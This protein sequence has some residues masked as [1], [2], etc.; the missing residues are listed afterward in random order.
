VTPYDPNDP[1]TR[2]RIEEA[3]GAL[4]AAVGRFEAAGAPP[5]EAAGVLLL[6]AADGAARATTTGEQF[7]H[8]ARHAWAEMLRLRGAR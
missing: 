3:L 8:L 7:E 4:A 1:A 6:L 2:A 5:A